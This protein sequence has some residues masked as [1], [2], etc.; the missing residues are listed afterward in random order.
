MIAES[1]VPRKAD[2]YNIHYDDTVFNLLVLILLAARLPFKRLNPEPKENQPP[3]R[4]CAHA[5]P[6]PEVPDGENE[7]ESSPILVHSG[8]PLV[9]GRGPLDGF[10]S[11]RHP[12]SSN[13]KAVIDLTSDNSTSPVKR[14]VP[15]AAASPCLQTKDKHKGKDKT[16][17]SGKSSS[18]DN[19]PETHT[20][21]C[22]VDSDEVEEVE[23]KDLNQTASISEL[24]TTQDS[25]SEPEE[26]NESGNV[27]SL[28]DR[29]MLSSPSVSSSCESS[30]EKSDDPT[31]TTTPSVCTSPSLDFYLIPLSNAS[32]QTILV[33]QCMDFFFFFVNVSVFITQKQY[34]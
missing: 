31:P 28:G 10:L 30:P 14:L 2:K 6:E 19:T 18:E 32:Y 3:K 34:R 16:A 33:H 17:S 22:T 11:R 7:N 29:S 5:C 27:S 8:P 4:P 12:A 23:D 25:E 9:N 24:D 20:L 13:E 1:P 15:P 26:Q 21:D